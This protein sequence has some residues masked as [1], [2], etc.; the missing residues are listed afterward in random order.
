MSDLHA[1]LL[2]AHD[3]GDHRALVTLYAE[4]AG[5]APAPAVPF[6]L[7]QAWIF[8]LEAGDSR[9]DALEARLKALGCA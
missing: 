7:T 2:A 4:A 8:A 6:F 5:Q 9:A 1:A 3:A